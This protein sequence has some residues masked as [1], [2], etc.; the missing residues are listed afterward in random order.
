MGRYAQAS[1]RG[2]SSVQLRGPP[3]AFGVS[4]GD[5]WTLEFTPGPSGYLVEI[6]E[7]YGEEDF[8]NHEV[9]SMQW[10]SG[11]GQTSLDPLTFPFYRARAR[12]IA[13]GQN[14]PW[15]VWVVGSA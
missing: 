9:I 3:D 5:Y 11:G 14:T 4:T 10:A 1:R 7:E 13:A 12:V 8:G 6:E 15:T 2:S